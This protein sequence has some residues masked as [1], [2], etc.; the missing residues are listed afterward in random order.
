MH[1]FA[2]TLTTSLRLLALLFTLL[3][4]SLQHSAFANAK[5]RADVTSD[6]A[7]NLERDRPSTLSGAAQRDIFQP[8]RRD[9]HPVPVDIGLY[10]EQLD[11]ISEVHHS[12]K[13]EAFVELIWCDPRLAYADEPNAPPRQ[14]FLEDRAHSLLS[15]IWWPDLSFSNAADTPSIQQEELIVFPDGTVIYEERVAVE[16]RAN[17]DFTRFPFDHQNLVIEIESF[18][19]PSHDMTLRREEDKIGFSQDFN[20]PTWTLTGY[21]SEI[22][23]VQEIRDRDTFSEL[24]VTIHAE[25]VS[26]PFV[27]RLIVPLILIVMVSWSVFWL[28]PLDTGRFGV[29]F[30][31][32]LT[33]VAFNFVVTDKLPNVPEITYLETLFAFA[34]T[35]LLLVVIENTAIDK[36]TAQ[37]RDAAAHRVDRISSIAFPLFFFVG[38]AL[39]TAAFG[40]L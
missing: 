27:Y 21:T 20:I 3:F 5:T 38:A 11:S 24:L 8:P 2:R 34:F 4:L 36:L 14:V 10:V 22:R 28:R 17:Y 15:E 37:G 29:T 13:I 9:D 16:V 40:V 30:T 39:V 25:R 35:F 7:C 6:A 12:F 26:S 31:T 18:S 23:N 19:W 33:V 32:I 1:S